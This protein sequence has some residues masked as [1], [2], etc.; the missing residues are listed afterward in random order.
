VEGVART[1]TIVVL[2]TAKE[3]V[4]VPIRNPEESDR[5]RR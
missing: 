4:V 5:D 2:S 1:R 3:T